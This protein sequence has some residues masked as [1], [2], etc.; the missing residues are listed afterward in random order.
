MEEA[1]SEISA[2]ERTA[3]LNRQGWEQMN[4]SEREA[5]EAIW[6]DTRIRMALDLNLA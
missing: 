2:E 1:N 4:A 6:H 3:F 5:L